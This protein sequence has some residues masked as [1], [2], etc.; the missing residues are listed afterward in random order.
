MTGVIKVKIEEASAKILTGNPDDQPEDYEIPVWAGILP[1][2]MK[3]D[4]CRM[5]RN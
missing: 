3:T 4:K 5:T 1:I 2:T